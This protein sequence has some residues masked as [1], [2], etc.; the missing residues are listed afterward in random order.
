MKGFFYSFSKNMNNTI[1][2]QWIWCSY[3][4]FSGVYIIPFPPLGER[5]QRSQKRG[6]GRIRGR[7]RGREGEGKEKG[8]SIEKVE[9]Q[10]SEL[11]EDIYSL[12]P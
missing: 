9:K 3:D 12:H 5:N 7:G 2:S 4:A 8:N 10:L 6:R 1:S 11:C